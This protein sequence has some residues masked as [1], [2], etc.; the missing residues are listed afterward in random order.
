M[1]V[2]S[3]ES[4]E[5]RLPSPDRP[6]WAW[7]AVPEPEPVAECAV[8]PEP[9]PEPIVVAEPEPVRAPAPAASA[10]RLAVVPPPYVSARAPER[11]GPLALVLATARAGAA[12]VTPVDRTANRIQRVLVMAFLVGG[13]ALGLSSPR[14]WLALPLVAVALLAAS[15]H[16]ALSVARLISA[17]VLPA[18][19][20]AGPWYTAEDPAPH[21]LGE[22]VTGA[23]LVLAS[24]CAALGA[25]VA[26]WTLGWAVIALSLVEFTFDVSLGAVLHGRLRRAG[27]L[28]V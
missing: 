6:A 22:A 20:L 1:S 12:G 5:G 23:V 4:H 8:A 10:P 14:L 3:H 2:Q 28:R 19:R 13:W 26:A 18:I 11:P 25:P 9:E 21:R 17:R 16:P 24:L 27:L 7:G 15:V